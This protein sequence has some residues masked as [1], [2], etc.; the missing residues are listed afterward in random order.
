MPTDCKLEFRLR[1][2]DGEYRHILYSGV[3]RFNEN[4]RFDSFIASCVDLTDVKRSEDEARARH[5]LESLGVL[6]GGIAHDFNNLLGGALAYVELAE[7][8]LAEGV[9][10]KEEL[11]QIRAVTIRG[12]EIV[13]ELMIFAG[14][15]SATLEQVDVSSVVGE[16]LELLKVSIS[17]HAILKTTLGKGLPPVKGNAAQILQVVMNLITNASEAI[18]ER[19]GVI[20]VI[21]ER[22]TASN[23]LRAEGLQSGE[24]V[25]IEVSDTGCGITL[26]NQRRLFEPFFTTKFVGRG[27]GLAVVQGVVQRHGGT[28]HVVS[29]HGKGTSVEILL[30]CAGAKVQTNDGVGMA[31]PVS[32]EPIPSRKRGILIV[33]DELPLLTAVSK[34]LQRRGFSVNQAS[35]GFSALEMFRKHKDQIDV[36]LLDLTLPGLSS[37]ELLLEAQR[38]RPDLQVILTSAYGQESVADSFS[39]LNVAHFIQKP[40]AIDDLVSLLQNTPSS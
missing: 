6:A 4:Q 16:M 3:P 19:D 35:D 39:G 21:T 2:A 36:L 1:R 14:K 34:M 13:R 12:S 25:R 32:H 29:S 5:N 33:E 22:A 11:E 26:E 9:P 40:F 15:E 27:M 10:P 24:S 17:K 37:H 18:G 7:A 38:L 23:V 31:R 30:P 28:V 8:Q 20:R